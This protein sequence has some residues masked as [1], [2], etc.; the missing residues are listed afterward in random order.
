MFLGGCLLKL[1]STLPYMALSNS[2][3]PGLV[4]LSGNGGATVR[5]YEVING[6]LIW[7]THL[8]DASSGE[9]PCPIH[10]IAHHFGTL[11][12]LTYR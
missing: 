11:N 5:L 1:S 2:S 9:L 6:K 12:Q 8:H 7:E 4:S 10:S 3:T